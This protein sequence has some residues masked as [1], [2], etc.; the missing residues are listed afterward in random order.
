M[1][2]LVYHID[3]SVDHYEYSRTV[4]VQPWPPGA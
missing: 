1:I 2:N 3:H 4:V